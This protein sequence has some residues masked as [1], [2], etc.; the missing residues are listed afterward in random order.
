MTKL[1]LCGPGDHHMRLLDGL[2]VAGM[3]N[4]VKSPIYVNILLISSES[5]KQML[6]VAS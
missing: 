5:I 6:F 4:T 1:V 2:A 3:E